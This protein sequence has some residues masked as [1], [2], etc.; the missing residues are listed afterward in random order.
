MTNSEAHR[1]GG[2]TL[3]FRSPA[4]RQ[5]LAGVYELPPMV[6]VQA[7]PGAHRVLRF[8][9]GEITLDLAEFPVRWDELSTDGLVRLLRTASA[10]SFKP[11][12][13]ASTITREARP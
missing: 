6:D 3:S 13:S 5:W 1:S 8:S 2:I 4:G 7:T 9:S 10:P 11:V 12:P